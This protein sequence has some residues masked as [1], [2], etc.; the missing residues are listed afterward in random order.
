MPR[1]YKVIKNRL[2]MIDKAIRTAMENGRK[3]N[4]S[5]LSKLTGMNSR[6][7]LRDIEYMRD[8]MKVPI[9]YDASK[10]SFYYTQENYYLKAVPLTEGEL[11]SIAL[12]DQLL[13]QYRNTPLE[14]ALKNIFTKIVQ[15]LPDNVSVETAFLNSQVS[16][17]SDKIG[18]ID[19][20]IFQ[21]IFAAMQKKRTLTF[22]YR[23]LASNEHT[24][25][26]ADPYHAICHRGNWYL[27]AYC[28]ERKI[29]RM[30]AF[31]RIKKAILNKSSFIIP[32]DF[33]PN[34]YFDK[35]MG[36]WASY[37]TPKT[38]EI[39]FIKEAKMYATERIWHSS[40]TIKENKDGS[41]TLK[42]TTTQIPEVFRWVLGQ[43]HNVKVLKPAELVKMV[44]TEIK[45]MNTIYK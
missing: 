33:D 34:K 35:E 8:V 39:R 27:I 36:V 15:S 5:N 42:F 1:E 12:F 40:Q 4:T 22:E 44:Q 19:L 13:E 32:T 45:K 23:S 14:E 18:N 26:N 17:I 21:V 11:F 9:E 30:F 2:L 6:T 37:Q 41:I 31:T 3:I 16:F 29:P 24:S 25:R 38:I 10:K 7:I 28:H 43:G 20:K